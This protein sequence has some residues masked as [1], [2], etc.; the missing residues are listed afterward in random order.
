MLGFQ[1]HADWDFDNLQE[2]HG[3]YSIPT[4]TDLILWSQQQLDYHTPFKIL[5]A[6]VAIS[7][8]VCEKLPRI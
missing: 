1:S 4:L 3:L 5:Q 8:V 7:T 2:Q 6:S